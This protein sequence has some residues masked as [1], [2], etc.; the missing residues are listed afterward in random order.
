[1]SFTDE[2]PDSTF[3]TFVRS[4]A[5]PT[6]IPPKLQLLT[7]GEALLR[8]RLVASLAAQAK[9]TATRTYVNTGGF[10]ARNSK[11]FPKAVLLALR[12]IDHL[13]LSIDSYHDK[14]ITR[15][16]QANLLRCAL[17]IGLEVS[18]Q[19][20][21]NSDK[22]VYVES[23]LEDIE[24]RFGRQIPILVL[25]LKKTGRGAT[26]QSIEFFREKAVQLPSPCRAAAWP[27][28]AFDGRVVACCNQRVVDG[29]SPSHL[30]LGCIE[31]GWPCIR[32]HATSSSALQYIRAMGPNRLAAILNQK[33]PGEM[34]SNCKSLKVPDDFAQ[35]NQE[36]RKDKLLIDYIQDLHVKPEFYAV[37][38]YQHLISNGWR[39]QHASR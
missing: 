6:S 25:P 31:S 12:Q 18:I 19:T 7:G 1:M 35:S 28:I 39:G 32:E 11:R 17:D 3:S 20:V 30:S 37:A 9:Q 14:E 27:V 26:I 24:N 34:C 22:D 2:L 21:A 10:F 13:S 33:A 23:L 5:D 16:E 38:N 8:P 4:Y 36:V 15:E 29:P